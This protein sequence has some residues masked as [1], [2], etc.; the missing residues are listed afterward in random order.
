M[1]V[2]ES[3]LSQLLAQSAAQEKGLMLA[4][5]NFRTGYRGD[6]SFAVAIA[7]QRAY[8]ADHAIAMCRSQHREQMDYVQRRILDV[9]ERATKEVADAS[10]EEYRYAEQIWRETANLADEFGDDCR[11]MARSWPSPEACIGAKM[12]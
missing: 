3:R 11:F 12:F 4:L 5:E 8:Q 10:R 6:N 1:Q 9:E 7:L 2:K